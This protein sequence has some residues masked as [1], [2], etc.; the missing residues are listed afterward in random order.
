MF[1]VYCCVTND[2]KLS[3]LQ[4]HPLVSSHFAWSGVWEDP[5]FRVSRGCNQGVSSTVVLTGSSESSSKLLYWQVVVIGL[6][7]LRA[8]FC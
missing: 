8:S 4:C 1:A 5:L 2:P 6:R 3:A 7:S